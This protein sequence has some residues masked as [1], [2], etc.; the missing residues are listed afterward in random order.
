MG[1]VIQFKKSCLVYGDNTQVILD[2]FSKMK[3]DS[4][5]GVGITPTGEFYI[6]S[7]DAKYHLITLGLLE[8]MKADIL[9][10]MT[11]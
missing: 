11:P 10:E 4:F 5:V 8:V 7:T 2:S 9:R 1:D 3:L 6:A